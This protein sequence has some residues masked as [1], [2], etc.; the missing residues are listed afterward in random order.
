MM[1]TIIKS[2]LGL[3]FIFVL[4]LNLKAQTRKPDTTSKTRYQL[5]REAIAKQYTDK[6]IAI[7]LKSP[8]GTKLAGDRKGVMDT[9]MSD[10]EAGLFGL[11]LLISLNKKQ[12]GSINPS[13]VHLSN[14]MKNAIAEIKAAKSLMTVQD[15]ARIKEAKE[16]KKLAELKSKSIYMRDLV[17]PIRNSFR[18]W[19][20]KGEFEKQADYQ[21]RI[22][23]ESKHYFDSLCRKQIDMIQRDEYEYRLSREDLSYDPEKEIL[24][25]KP[26]KSSFEVKCSPQEAQQFSESVAGGSIRLWSRWICLMLDSEYNFTWAKAIFDVQGSYRENNSTTEPSSTLRGDKL[27]LGDLSENKPLIRVAFDDLELDI[28]TLKGYIF[29]WTSQDA[30]A[31]LEDNINQE[32]TGTTSKD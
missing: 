16:L 12:Y 7:S 17:N 26:K 18:L 6:I 19:A 29:I 31:W 4:C 8:I 3:L 25:I 2:L 21:Q 9:L 24:Y 23:S 1:N 32:K 22:N 30:E 13:S 10:E 27:C 28:P 20:N 15:K 11:T 14:T 5:R